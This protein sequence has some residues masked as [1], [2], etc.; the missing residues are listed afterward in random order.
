MKHLRKLSVMRADAFTALF[1][2]LWRAWYDF[3]GKNIIDPAS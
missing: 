2:D 1:N 3:R